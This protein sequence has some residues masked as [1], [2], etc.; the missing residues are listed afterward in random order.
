M[1]VSPVSPDAEKNAATYGGEVPASWLGIHSAAKVDEGYDLYV[2][3]LEGR[4]DVEKT[5]EEQADWEAKSK[6]IAKKY[7]MW[8]LP[9]LCFLVGVNYIDKAA[10]AWAV[11]F[12]F[13]EDLG[14]VGTDYSLI[15]SAFYFGYL[16]VSI[17]QLQPGW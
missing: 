12:G 14:L 6:G 13:R 3:A 1:S 8:L 11:L 5:V 10:L 16:G 17:H 4:K 15:S 2:A 9:M 7:D